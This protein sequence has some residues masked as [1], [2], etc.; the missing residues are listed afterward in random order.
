MRSITT[1]SS[2]TKHVHHTDRWP[3]KN[4]QGILIFITNV[5]HCLP[6]LFQS[7]SFMWSSNIVVNG[8]KSIN[9]QLIHIAIVHCN[10]VVLR[11]LKITAPST[12]LNT[13]GIHV[14]SSTGITISSS[15]IKTG[16]D[17]IS[18][19]QGSKNLWIDHIACGPGHGIR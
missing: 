16:D 3:I 4:L 6:R 14:Q 7:I 1:N 19:G 10:D 5:N 13:D 9:S 17:C 8:L 12:S 18:I 15:M 11:N 2:R